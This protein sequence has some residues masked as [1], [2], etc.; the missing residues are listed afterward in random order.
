MKHK[1]YKRKPGDFEIRIMCDGR[2]VMVAPDETLMEVAKALDPENTKLPVKKE[3]EIHAR[4][5]SHGSSS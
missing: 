3:T 5:Q 1:Y 2:V 4:V